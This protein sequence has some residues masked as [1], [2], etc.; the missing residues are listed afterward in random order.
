MLWSIL[1]LT[2]LE[3]F[4]NLV[5]EKLFILLPHF[6]LLIGERFFLSLWIICISHSEKYLFI[7]SAHFSDVCLSQ[8]ILIWIFCPS[9]GLGGICI[10]QF[11]FW[12]L[13]GFFVCLFVCSFTIYS[14]VFMSSR[15][16]KYLVV[17]SNVF[18]LFISALGILFRKAYITPMLYKFPLTFSPRTCFVIV[19]SGERQQKKTLWFF[20]YTLTNGFLDLMKHSINLY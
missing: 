2:I 9:N 4:T 20:F 15:N 7:S 14:L 1:N 6:L 5:G 19:L 8:L 13:L 18:Y 17:Q 3:I 11:A 10:S 16:V 12:S